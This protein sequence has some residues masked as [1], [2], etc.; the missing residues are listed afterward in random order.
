MSRSTVA[1]GRMGLLG[2]AAFVALSMTVTPALGD[3]MVMAPREY[4]GSLEELA[5]EAIL[6]F[7]PGDDKRSA[8]EDLILKIRVKGDSDRFAW[9]I[10]LPAEPESAPEESALF[11]ELHRYVQARLTPRPTKTSGALPSPKSAA[12][13]PAAEAP[14]EVLSRKDVGNFDVAVVRENQPGALTKWLTDNGFRAPEA[15]DDVIGSYRKKGYVFACVKVSEAAKGKGAEASLHPL[16]FTFKTGGKDGIYFPMR[17]TGLQSE[18]FDVNLYVFY[19]KWIND[20]VSR[21]GFTHRGFSL[22]WRDYDSPACEPNAGK[23]WTDPSAD[24]YLK[25]Y[26]SLFP[27]VTTL[28]R[29]LHPGARYY[30][31]NIRANGLRA[32]DVRAWSDDLWLFPYYID[33][34]M[35]PYDAREGG[36]AASGFPAEARSERQSGSRGSGWSDPVTAGGLLFCSL[37]FVLTGTIALVLA[38]RIRRAKPGPPDYGNAELG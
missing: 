30:L 33:P 28:F 8:T 5:Q 17:L 12:P 3:G 26:E 35:V 31:T 36:P 2:F 13:A 25:G 27:T 15:A 14:V 9:I 7:H 16:R 20:R 1:I 32:A 18:P 10:P 19:D 37:I 11:E 21:Y 23:S 29:K 34:K 4:K 24:P 22:I 38:V 6:V